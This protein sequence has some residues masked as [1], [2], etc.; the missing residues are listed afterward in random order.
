[1]GNDDVFINRTLRNITVWDE[2]FDS[3]CPGRHEKFGWWWN[4]KRLGPYLE[5]LLCEGPECG[6]YINPGELPCKLDGA[7]IRIKIEI[8][9]V[10]WVIR[11][12][13]D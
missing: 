13:V 9:K 6:T 5:Y 11:E 8:R 10:K 4:K 12:E 1:M 2:G 7:N 3:L